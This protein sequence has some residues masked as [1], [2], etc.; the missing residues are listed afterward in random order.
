MAGAERDGRLLFSSI[1]VTQSGLIQ[2]LAVNFLQLTYVADDDSHGELRAIVQSHG[3][4]GS[5]SA[6]FNLSALNE[7]CARLGE[8]PID[9][10]TPAT[11]SGGFLSKTNPA[12]LKQEH[13]SI[14]ISPYDAKGSVLVQVKLATP[15]WT[16]DRVDRGQLVTARFLVHYGDL[17]RFQN[18]FAAMLAGNVSEAKLQAAPD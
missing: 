15:V 18:S 17:S 11:L 8:Y 10:Q 12:I 6:W 5:G 3:Y 4:A 2:H 7:F 14:D 16:N 13:L 9:A 1:A